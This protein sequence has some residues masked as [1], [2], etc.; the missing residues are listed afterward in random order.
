[1]KQAYNAFCETLKGATWEFSAP[2]RL[3]MGGTL[4]IRTFNTPLRMYGPATVNFAINLRTYVRIKSYRPG[5][6]KI[7]AHGIDA[8]EALLADAS[9]NQPLGLMLAIMAAMGGE[10]LEVEIESTSPPRGALGGSSAAAVTLVKALSF[11]RSS[12]FGEPELL[13]FDIAFL[14]HN[15]EEGVAR[16]PC[17]AQ[18]QLAAAYGGINMWMWALNNDAC[19][20]AGMHLAKD[21]GITKL[22]E[23]FAVA[24]CG[25]PHDSA[26][27][28]MQWVNSFLAG[29]HRQKWIDTVLLT[30]QFGQAVKA[31]NM[32]LMIE[33]MNKEAD[34]RYAM[35]PDVLDEAGKELNTAARNLGCGCRFTGAGGGGCLWALG[36][37]E[38]IAALKKTWTEIT[39]K[40][41]GAKVLEAQIDTE[42]AKF[43]RII[44]GELSGGE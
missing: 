37:P 42:G 33:S 14:A 17:G 7:R 38:N 36:E 31:H 35:T 29:E 23:C 43:E 2:C 22:Q 13:H 41:P 30:H 34:L 6:V 25:N 24:Y 10:G 39:A 18:D 5:R 16:I 15:V 1:M 9:F 3:D 11:L 28:N 4:D 26:D 40:Y 44:S 8:T 27:I 20:Y 12:A 21:E 32:P 19:G